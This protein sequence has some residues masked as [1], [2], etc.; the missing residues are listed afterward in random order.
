MNIGLDLDEIKVTLQLKVDGG[1]TTT[2]SMDSRMARAMALQLVSSA[3]A[4]DTAL[5]QGLIKE[6]KSGSI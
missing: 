6:V 4:L 3:D 2:A 5:E 1:L